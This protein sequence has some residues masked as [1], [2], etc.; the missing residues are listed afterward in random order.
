MRLI[1]DWRQSW[2]YYSQI[3]NF[4]TIAVSLIA[5]SDLAFGLLPYWQTLIDPEHYAIA[6]AITGSL[7]YVGR[8]IQ[9]SKDL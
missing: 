5:I 6:T 1:K 4:S 9:Q 7:G 2:R 3:A 8:V